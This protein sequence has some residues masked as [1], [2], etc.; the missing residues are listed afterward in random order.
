L[1]AQSITA[2]FDVY[3]WDIVSSTEESDD[4]DDKNTDAAVNYCSLCDISITAH[5]LVIAVT[6]AI[7][8]QA[9]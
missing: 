2:P 3:V 6:T 4:Y 9:L 5:S 8:L 7:I 1:T